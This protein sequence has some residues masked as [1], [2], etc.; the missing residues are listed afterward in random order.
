MSRVLRDAA[1]HDYPAIC[2]LL[3]ASGL[4]LDGVP[5]T[6][7]QFHVAEQDGALLG[8]V[9]LEVHGEDG[10]LRSLAVAPWHRGTG[11]GGQLSDRIVGAARELGLHHL[12]L[13]TETAREYFEQRGFEVVR[14]ADVPPALRSSVE[15]TRACPESAIAMSRSVRS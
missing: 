15:F 12:Y 3:E 9:G 4:P 5:V 14:R 2:G 8:V 11:L 10:L 6:L 1:S 13:L 7:D